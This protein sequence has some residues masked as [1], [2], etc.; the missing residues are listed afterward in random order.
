[1]QEDSGWNLKE[2]KPKG[3]NKESQR[4]VLEANGFT[5][6][7]ELGRKRTSAGQ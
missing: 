7:E 6:G 2:K 3:N 1:V 5:S 4:P